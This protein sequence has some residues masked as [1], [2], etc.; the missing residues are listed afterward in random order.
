ALW[1]GLYRGG[2]PVQYSYHRAP[3]ALWSVQ[4]AFAGRPWA[5]EMPSAGR[6]LDWR[7]LGGLRR[8][9]V[10]LARLTHAAGLSSSGDPAMDRLLPLP[11]RYAIPEATIAAITATQA[12]GGRII[13]VGTTVVRALEGSVAASG[14]LRAGV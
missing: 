4:S 2:A 9:G 8:A 14:R 3:L 5:A 11:E 7:T 1:A 13:A 6:P 12:R 10:G